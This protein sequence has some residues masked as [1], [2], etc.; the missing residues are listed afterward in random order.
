MLSPLSLIPTA[1][2]ALAVVPRVSA[3]GWVA[4]V[5]IDG[6]TYQG[7][8]PGQSPPIDSPIREISQNGPV[9]SVTDPDMACGIDAQTASQVAPAAP[10]S[11]VSFSWVSGDLQNPENWIHKVGP[12][13]TYMA[14][15]EGTTCDKFNASQ[16]EWFKIAQAGVKDSG[17]G[18]PVWYMNDLNEG[19]PYT[20]QLPDDLKS[21]QYLIR[22]ELIGLQGAQS[23]GG[24]EFYPS[25][26]QLDVSGTGDAVPPLNATFGFAQLYTQDD[27]GL[28]VDVYKSDLKYTFPGPPIAELVSQ[29][30]TAGAEGAGSSTDSPTPSSASSASTLPNTSQPTD[31]PTNGT[32]CTCGAGASSG[33]EQVDAATQTSQSTMSTAGTSSAASA[34]ATSTS[35]DCG[36]AP[37][38]S[39]SSSTM[40]LATE[41]PNRRRLSR[42]LK[43]RVLERI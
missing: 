17:S 11:N 10:G 28:V 43:R 25:C 18:M 6:K 14:L 9:K 32:A 29:N 27:P 33:G 2:L 19:K 8:G 20:L 35:M 15:C 31:S 4:N 30:G 13:M 22:N 24:V 41:A 23:P 1:L 26:T 3:H 34:T 36:D 40:T 21:G 38:L 42:M 37:A 12:I 5:T 7:N 16:A 39:S